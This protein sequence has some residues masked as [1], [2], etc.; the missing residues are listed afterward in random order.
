MKAKDI[1][2]KPP[3]ILIYGPMGT[4]KTSLV[5]QASNGYMFDFDDGMLIANRL[6]DSFS[7]LRR[8]IEYDTY[9]DKNPAK[10]TAWLAARKKI[11][12]IVP[13]VQAGTW[14]FDAVVVD[15][16][17]GLG[18]CIQLHV[19]ATTGDAFAQPKIQHYGAMINEL[20]RFLTFMRAC[21]VLR[22]VTA[23]QLNV[24][25]V[26]PGEIFPYLDSTKPLSITRPHSSDKLPWLYDD[27]W[28]SR[29]TKGAMS[30]N[31][32]TV[33]GAS[34]TVH[35]SKTR[36]GLL[37]PVNHDEIGLKGLLEKAGYSYGKK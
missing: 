10:P 6:E 33:S 7:S 15:S 35:S 11:E 16:L 25:R 24:E 8:N 1:T 5:S 34:D 4:K 13:R 27:I 19:M 20:E 32:F 23:H 31:I 12:Q 28:H 3:H 17:T 30:K 26:K 29:V 18:K 36:S 37:A 14:E 22:L 2:N 9:V 21:P